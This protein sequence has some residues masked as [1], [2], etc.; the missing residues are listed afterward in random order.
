VQQISGDFSGEHPVLK[1]RARSIAERFPKKDGVE[2]MDHRV[3]SCGVARIAGDRG[4][5]VRLGTVEPGDGVPERANLAGPADGPSSSPSS[6]LAA[7]LSLQVT[8]S[9][10][11]GA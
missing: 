11:I 7:V 6:R 2:V 10:V 4:V 9:L 8:P 3:R 1:S 5:Q